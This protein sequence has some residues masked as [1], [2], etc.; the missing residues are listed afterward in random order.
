TVRISHAARYHDALGSLTGLIAPQWRARLSH[1]YT[2]YPVQCDNRDALLRDSLRAG[3]DFAPQYLRHCADL[4][5]F[6]E[7]HRDCPNA[8]AAAR[9]LVL[10]PTY[11]RYPAEEIDKNI[12]V[13]RNFAE[14]RSALTA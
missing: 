10:L 13:V 5:D 9:E 1:I 12:D 2:Y 3:R 7:F 4:P 11:P 14:R 6:K 8:R